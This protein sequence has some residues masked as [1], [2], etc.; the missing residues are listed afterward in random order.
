MAIRTT[1]AAIAAALLCLG[2][3]AAPSADHAELG[4]ACSRDTL[5]QRCG[6]LDD[7][8]CLDVRTEAASGLCTLD[9]APLDSQSCARF[10]IPARCVAGLPGALQARCAAECGPGLRCPYAAE[11][12]AVQLRDGASV[13]LCLPPGSTP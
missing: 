4:G 8:H 5:G 9:C 13:S 10:G 12:R 3:S 1:T 2:C 6:L 7:V 11:C